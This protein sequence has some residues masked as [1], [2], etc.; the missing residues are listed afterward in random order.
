MDQFVMAGL[1]IRGWR[2][3]RLAPRYVVISR[4][5]AFGGAFVRAVTIFEATKTPSFEK[6]L[7]FRST[8]DRS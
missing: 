5:F 1:N 2:W 4:S 7:W 8:R 3:G 6:L